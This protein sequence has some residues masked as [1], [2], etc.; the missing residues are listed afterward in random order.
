MSTKEMAV[1]GGWDD[2]AV[3]RSVYRQADMAAMIEVI[4]APLKLREA[5]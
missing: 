5:R 3:L 4:E 2:E 1:L